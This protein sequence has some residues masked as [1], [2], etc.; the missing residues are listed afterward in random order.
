M[1]HIRNRT[2]ETESVLNIALP[3]D[4]SIA[5]DDAGRH[6]DAVSLPDFELA[7]VFDPEFSL[8][9]NQMGNGVDLKNARRAFF[10]GI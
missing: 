2:V 1:H 10:K 4:A 3:V 9:L 6:Q 5:V 8:S 7:F